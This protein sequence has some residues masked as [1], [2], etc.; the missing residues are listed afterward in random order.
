MQAFNNDT[1]LKN[2]LVE[3]V[4]WHREQDRIIAGTYGKFADKNFK[5]C[6]VG[7][8]L[9]SYGI[10]NKIEI[11][12]SDH[13]SY[14]LFGIPRLLAKLEDGIFEGLLEKEQKVW[15]EQFMQA[16]NVGADLSTVWPKFAVWLLVDKKHGVIQY[17]KNDRQRVADLYKKGG[18]KKEF[19]AAAYAYAAVRRQA[20]F[21]TRIAQSKKLIRL[22]KSCKKI[23]E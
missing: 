10:I 12:T 20:K 14:E 17:A 4:I 1:E 2:K 8:S 11:D 19:A 7:C 22:L 5:G 21:N 16:I 6:A 9:H 23:G 13:K 15:P 18:T 3:Q